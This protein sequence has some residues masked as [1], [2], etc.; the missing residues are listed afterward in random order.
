MLS[1]EF[2]E[3]KE[4]LKPYLERN[5]R[6]LWIGVPKRGAVFSYF[7]IFLIPFSIVWFGFS[8]LW[9]SFAL[10][11]AVDEGELWSYIF[12]LFGLPFVLLGYYLCIGRFFAAAR[13]RKKTIYAFSEQRVLV[14]IGEKGPMFLYMKD[15]PAL[16]L[17]EKKDASGSV[18]FNAIKD[19]F[20]DIKNDVKVASY[21]RS[22]GF[23]FEYIPDAK[24]VY[25]KI[26]QLME[27]AKSGESA[28][29]V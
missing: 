8:L 18:H 4:L 13:R 10:W 26:N 23:A 19:L 17:N 12:P 1:F 5:E 27:R 11:A 25:E 3:H 6:L 28:P 14:K 16:T 9:E 22:V 24:R 2:T 21:I 20:S 29:S 15:I 7:D